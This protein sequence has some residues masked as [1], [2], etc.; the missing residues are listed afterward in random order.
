MDYSDSDLPVELSE[1]DVATLADGT[2][3][4]YEENGGA[5][6]VM[7]GGEWS[8]TC[9]LFPGN[10]H[11]LVAGE[12]TYVLTAMDSTLKVESRG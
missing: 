5:R 2:T 8:P 11:T 12:K 3:V 9:S 6:D 4:R 1:G 7:L 10:T